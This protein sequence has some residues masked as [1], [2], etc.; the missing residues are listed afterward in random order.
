MTCYRLYTK[1]KS[2]RHILVTLYTLIFTKFH[3]YYHSIT[4]LY[5]AKNTYCVCIYFRSTHASSLG[6]SWVRHATWMLNHANTRLKNVYRL[7]TVEDPR[8]RSIKCKLATGLVLSASIHYPL[9]AFPQTGFEFEACKHHSNKNYR[10][11]SDTSP[12]LL[13]VHV[14]FWVLT[15][16]NVITYLRTSILTRHN[17]DSATNSWPNPAAFG[18]WQPFP[19]WEQGIVERWPFMFSRLEHGKTEPNSG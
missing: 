17:I 8:T 13:S 2:V 1:I 12:R 15:F 19:T 18:N 9:C 6:W 10:K 16:H 4:T 14:P 11:T 3:T 5:T 7:C